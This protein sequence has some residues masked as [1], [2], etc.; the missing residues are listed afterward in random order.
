MSKQKIHIFILY[1]II[2]TTFILIGI[3]WFNQSKAISKNRIQLNDNR[4]FFWDIYPEL[5]IPNSGKILNGQLNLVDINNNK[6]KLAE[7]SPKLPLLIF[8]YSQYDCH[9]CINQVLVKLQ[10]AFKGHESRVCL[11]VDGMTPRDFRIKNKDSNLKIRPYF[12][13]SQYLGISLENKNLPFLFV[14]NPDFFGIDKIFIPF[15]EYP[16]QT[17]A[18]LENVKTVLND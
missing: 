13:D 17:D 16:Q 8:R 2:A 15:K 4:D 3:Q 12:I 9:L 7:L 10:L 1:F 6:I 14:M 18:Y 5:V 11:I